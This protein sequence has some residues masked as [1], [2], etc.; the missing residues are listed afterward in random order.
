MRT[1]I[2]VIALAG[3]YQH[4]GETQCTI[5]CADNSPCPNGLPCTNG[6]CGVCT[7]ADAGR[8]DGAGSDAPSD[9]VLCYGHLGIRLCTSMANTGMVVPSTSID[10]DTGCS[11]VTIGNQTICVISGTDIFIQDPTSATGTLPLVLFATNSISI[12]SGGSVD[13]SSS[14]SFGSAGAGA[15]SAACPAISA[16]G[17]GAGAGG[18]FRAMP[19]MGGDGGAGGT[20]GTIDPGAAAVAGPAMVTTVRGGCAG[21]TGGSAG[22]NSGYGGHSG[23][24]VYLLAGNAIHIDG[25]I[26]ASGAGGDGGSAASTAGGGGGG[27]SGGLIVLDAATVTVTVRPG[28]A[29]LFAE[30]G[31]GGGGGVLSAGLSSGGP[32]SDP[33]P[34]KPDLAAMGGLGGDSSAGVGGNGSV[35]DT[36]GQTGTSSTNAT[37]KY[38]GGGGGGGGPGHIYTY[39]T[40]MMIGTPIVAPSIEPQ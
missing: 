21:G 22:G 20:F 24:A 16:S 3:C 18:S 34:A 2:V 25:L 9:G 12:G 33:D 36:A 37:G 6:V 30:G 13:V 31:S 1:A 17:G 38:D 35:F 14:V 11:P 28:A 32:G 15:D 10:T 23:G 19:E 4:V 7:G 39:G 27:G 29:S 26:N 8:G 40:L 5:S